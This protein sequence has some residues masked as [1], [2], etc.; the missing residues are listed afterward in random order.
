MEFGALGAY[1]PID[2]RGLAQSGAAL[3]IFPET[4]FTEEEFAAV[5]KAARTVDGYTNAGGSAEF[6]S[7]FAD[8]SDSDTPPEA[9]VMQI[10]HALC[11]VSG[12][13]K[14]IVN[15]GSRTPEEEALWRR[16]AESFGEEGIPDEDAEYGEPDWDTALGIRDLPLKYPAHAVCVDGECFTY[17]I[18]FTGGKAGKAQ[19]DAVREAVS[20]PD[21]CELDITGTAGKVTVYLDLGNAACEDEDSIVQ[22]I[23]RSLNDVQGIEKV[24][25]NDA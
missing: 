21:S 4:V 11:G 23:L 14:V 18:Y 1:F 20:A 10:L 3:N 19:L 13:Q 17:D 6:M 24:I 2:F 5:C 15:D 8:C 9:A 22:G 16:L 12:I 7:I 25:I